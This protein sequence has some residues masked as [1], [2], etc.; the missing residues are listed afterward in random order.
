MTKKRANGEGSV[1]KRADG[2]V[3]GVYE[4]TN[5]KTR[6]LTSKTMTKVEMKAAVRKKLEERDQGIV[7]DSENLTVE[8]YMV[9]HWLPSIR[10]KVRPGTYRPYESIVRLHINPTLGTTKLEKLTAMQLEK[11]YRQK[12]Q[13]GLSARRVKYIHVTI[14]KALKDAVRLQLLPRNVADAAQPLKAS[15]AKIKPLTQGQMRTLLDTA[16]GD[17]LEA[18]YVLA[19]TTGMRQGELLGLQ[20]K[21]IDLEAGTLTVNRSVYDGEVNPPKTEA[22]NRTIKLSNMAVAALRQHR[23]DAATRSERISE[24]VFPNSKGDS[25]H[26]QNLHN[27]SWKP[28]LKRAGLPHSTRFHDL[29]HSCISLLLSRGVPVHV[30][31]H[32]AGHGN[33]AITF[34]IYAHVLTTQGELAEHMDSALGDGLSYSAPIFDRYPTIERVP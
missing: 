31:S 25:I 33:P 13:E 20:W 11:L 34:T 32:M 21:D 7:Y 5:G 28:L 14:R 27:R 6:Y 22:G 29:R 15:K 3:V 10:D 2:R 30:V 23:I 17:N 26:H 1:F 12:L 9:D 16:K 18:L 24:W 4:D 19:I 8:R